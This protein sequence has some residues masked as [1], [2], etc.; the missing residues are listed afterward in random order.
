MKELM[1]DGISTFFIN[2]SEYRNANSGDL[3][4]ISAESSAFPILFYTSRAK[5]A[6]KYTH[7]HLH[8]HPWNRPLFIFIKEPL[9]PLLRLLHVPT[10]ATF[11]QIPQE[12]WLRLIKGEERQEWEG[13]ASLF[14]ESGFDE[15][16]KGLAGQGKGLRFLL[17]N[18]VIKEE[19]SGLGCG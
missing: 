8:P 15:G 11:E 12:L 17:R 6:Q 4:C 1:I 3:D 2:S 10:C 18:T 19:S 9:H 16:L 7:T 13:R 5:K 14:W